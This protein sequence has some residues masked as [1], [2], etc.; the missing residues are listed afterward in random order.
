M[1]LTMNELVEKYLSDLK[2]K[3]YIELSQLEDYHG[4]KVVKNRKSYTISVWRDTISS[5]ELRVVVQ[6]YRYW[7]LGIGKMGADGFTI[8]REGK[9]SDLTRTELYEF[10]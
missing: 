6:I 3:S 4:E 5:N 9:I 7:F 8:N 10:I 2:K 1:V